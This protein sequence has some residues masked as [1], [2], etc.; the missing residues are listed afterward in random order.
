M[1]LLGSKHVTI[2]LKW[3]LERYNGVVWTALIWL[4]IGLVEGSCEHGNEP[5]DS[6]KCWKVLE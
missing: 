4:R 5:S 2:V 1:S 3:I 6:I